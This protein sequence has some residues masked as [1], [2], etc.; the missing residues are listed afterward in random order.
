MSLRLFFA[1]DLPPSVRQAI[2]TW[3]VSRRF[4]GRPEPT[5]NLHITLVFLGTYPSDSGSLDALTEVATRAPL[6]PFDIAL[7]RATRWQNGILHLAPSRVPPEMAELHRA[8]N[9]GCAELGL[10]VDRRRFSPHVTLARECP[11]WRVKRPPSFGWRA[12]KLTLFS[13][14]RGETGI[15]YRPIRE[16]DMAEV[17]AETESGEGQ[18]SASSSAVEVENA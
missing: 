18:P 13:S 9:E 4:P 12:N 3:R 16:W 2:D 7:D 8:L 1:I 14:E 15:T 10:K 11:P 5:P 6:R 17:E